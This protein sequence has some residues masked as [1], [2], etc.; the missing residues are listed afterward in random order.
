[1]V[2]KEGERGEG[3]C[4]STKAGGGGESF[5]PQNLERKVFLPNKR[6]SITFAEKKKELRTSRFCARGKKSEMIG[7]NGAA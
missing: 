6:E 1:L 5:R 7:E 3:R 2:W 4:R